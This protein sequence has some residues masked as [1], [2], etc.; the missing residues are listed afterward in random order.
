MRLLLALALA[1]AA[2]LA[3][4]FAPP[5]PRA[6]RAALGGARRSEVSRQRSKMIFGN[7]FKNENLGKAPGPA[8][9]PTVTIEFSNGKTVSAIP[10]QK[11][12]DVARAAGAK[13]RY[14][15]KNGDC[16]TCTVKLNGRAVRTCVAKVPSGGPFKVQVGDEAGSAAA[17][18]TQ[19][20]QDQLK[21]ENGKKKGFW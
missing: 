8:P 2:P 10:G 5:S 20:M 1:L 12:S 17:A 14:D 18:K 21:A 19:N 16:G 13:V 7:A 11:L 3:F 9:K 6:A 4:S 15:C